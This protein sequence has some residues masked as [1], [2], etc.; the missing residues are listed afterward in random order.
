MVVEQD[1]TWKLHIHGHQVN[2]QCLF[3]VPTQLQAANLTQLLSSID[4]LNVCAGHPDAHFVEIVEAKKGS[5]KSATGDVA[6]YIDSNALVE[7]NG[8]RYSKTLRSASC[9]LLSSASK[10]PDCVAYRDNIRSTYHRWIKTTPSTSA[11]SS[12]TNDRWMTT[13]ERRM[14]TAELKSRVRSA[15]SAVKYMK[16]KIASSVDK[17]GISVDDSLHV[18]LH[19]LMSEYSANV[20]KKY[21]ENSFHMLFWDQ[22]MKMLAKDPKQ[23]RWHPMLIRWCLHLKMMSSAAYNSFREVLTLPCGRTLQV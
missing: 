21:A 2:P 3:N 12:H 19:G 11:S 14:K 1:R 7:L 23:R 20:K 4:Q 10:C 22:Q 6:A 17:T 9:Q 18:G 8:Q 15:E 5:L 16:K 13:P